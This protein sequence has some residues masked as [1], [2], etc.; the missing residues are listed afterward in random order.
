MADVNTLQIKHLRTA[1]DATEW[2]QVVRG[3]DN[4]SGAEATVTSPSQWPV[5]GRPHDNLVTELAW[6]LEEFLGYPF[7]PETEHADRVQ[8]SLRSWGTS[9]FEA[10]F[11]D[12]N[13]R[14]FYDRA[15]DNGLESLQLQISSDDPRILAWPWESLHDPQVGNLA[16]QCQID[17][18]LNELRD[19]YEISDEL[20]R[21]QV[22]ILLITARPYEKDAKYRSITR[23][24][25]E[26]IKERDL[27]AEVT[28]LRP[29]TFQRL[30]DHL[31]ERP[32]YYHIVHFDGHG[33]YSAELSVPVPHTLTLRGPMGRLIFEKEDGTADPKDAELLSNLLREYRIPAVVLNACQSAMIG[34]TARD[35]FASVAASMLKAGVRGVVA[36]AY[37]VYVSG[38]Q[39][40]LPAFYERLFE[41]GNIAEATR[42]GRQQM[43]AEPKRVCSRGQFPLQ[44]WL[45][46]VV[47]QQDPPDFS[48][49]QERQPKAVDI[50][51]LAEEEESTEE[52][53]YGFIG[54]DTAILALERAI[55]RP[56]PA[57][58]IHGLG[59]VGKTTLARGFLEW[60]K[61]TNGLKHPPFW[62]SFQ[63]TFNAESVLN[64]IG[65]RIFGTDFNAHP[66]EMRLAALTKQL[67]QEPYLIVWD[68]FEDVRGIEGTSVRA[69][70]PESD[71]VLLRTFVKKLYG[72]KSKVLITSRSREDWLGDVRF[73]LDLGGLQGEERWEYCQKILHDLGRSIDPTKPDPELKNLMDLL[74]GHP[75][76]MRVVLPRLAEQSAQ[77]IAAQVKS[78]L[79]AFATAGDDET[80]AKL[81]AT[82][83]FVET[84]VPAE[85]RP[86]L[87][88][89]G[90]HEQ[91]VLRPMLEQ[92]AQQVDASWT[93]ERIS[94]LLE[95]LT[96]AGLLRERDQAIFEI[97]PALTGFLRT[98][99]VEEATR[100]PWVDAFVA[101][102]ALLADLL[103]ARPLH[104]QRGPFHLLG[105]SFRSAQVEAERIQAQEFLFALTQSLAAFSENSHDY[106]A[107]ES[108]LQRYAT[109]AGR[110]NNSTEQAKAYHQLGMIAQE[111]R[112]F[113]AAESWY[114]KS[115]EIKERQG[116]EHG[117]ALT[118]W[119]FGLMEQKREHWSAAGRWLVKA[120]VVFRRLQSPHYGEAATQALLGLEQQM[121]DNERPQLLKIWQEAGLGPF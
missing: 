24:L 77:S 91:F 63:E 36:M 70:L 99:E 55:R 8:E 19:P 72:G 65:E 79:A 93:G 14:G 13:S 103:V 30:R 43:L 59:G 25:V 53:R 42:A 4:K 94:R 5:E 90:L 32:G 45:I 97:H 110:F 6:Y 27:P 60:L 88:P 108:E 106:A 40:F 12:A 44:D 102:M 37:S 100:A 74:N 68:N 49:A 28:I 58:L 73:K 89:L 71:Q 80:Q 18:Q 82:L 64:R 23:R 21:D 67:K 54:R 114:R 96:I 39:Q 109:M 47:Y 83:Q 35:P 11:R 113:D 121:P 78:N 26:L 86:L 61:D 75:L 52:N 50:A 120:L 34:D 95:I 31:R 15:A 3:R 92:M 101:V 2:F 87:I 117:A 69:K 46:P 118:Y 85:L 56:P 81:F 76:M 112:A 66:L 51:A 62:F 116:N 20:P 29:P 111:R 10:L 41:K 16:Q 22:N 1:D 107:A 38:A 7:H 17:R 104:E 48:F 105:A 115:L 84:T 98:T 33:S 119:A 57:I 9:A